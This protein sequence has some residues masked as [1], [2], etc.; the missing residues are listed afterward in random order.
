MKS[1]IYFMGHH[2]W[3]W[4]ILPAVVIAWVASRYVSKEDCNEF[5]AYYFFS[6]LIPIIG[7][8]IWYFKKEEYS[9]DEIANPSLYCS[10]AGFVVY[11]LILLI[12]CM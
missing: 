2:P 4:P 5:Y 9:K 12:V 10:I 11:F 8:L 1:F 7:I 3:T 6:A